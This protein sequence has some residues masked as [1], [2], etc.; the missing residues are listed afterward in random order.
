VSLTLVAFL[1]LYC[2]LGVACLMRHPI[3][4]VIG[5]YVTYVVSPATRWWGEPAANLGFRFNYIIAAVALLG[6]LLHYRES[7]TN[8][9]ISGQECLLW[10]YVGI[11]WFAGWMHPRIAG[12][13]DQALKLA[14]AVLMLSVLR[15][16][17]D[18]VGNFRW[19]IWALLLASSYGA[20][21]TRL[22]ADRIGN[23]VQSGAGGSDFLE[24]NFLAAHLTM[25]LP[26]LGVL[27]IQG[28]W[29]SKLF[30]AAAAA[31][32][33]D[34]IIQCRSRGAFLALL[35]GGAIALASAPRTYRKKI[36][37]LA[38]AGICGALVLVDTGFWD[39]IGQITTHIDVEEQDAS[40]AGRLLAWRAAIGMSADSPLGV[41]YNNF[42]VHVGRYSP[43]IPGKDT[44]ST[45]LRALAEL[46]FQ[47]LALLVLLIGNALYQTYRLHRWM[48]RE[49]PSSEYQLYVYATGASLVTY[50]IACTFISS[51]YVEEFYLILLFPDLLSGVRETAR[52]ENSEVQPELTRDIACA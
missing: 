30:L 48:R 5:Y 45:Y 13:E 42:K 26:F 17:I 12:G 50:L 51:T 25:I 37:V 21:D 34:V 15:R 8:R 43:T 35:G 39:R 3:Y 40:S 36:Y 11:V 1:A 28:R 47:G 27:F 23:R 7:K 14:K 33:V 52:C 24:G 41:G 49:T 2:A 20:L 6:V 9:S 10:A 44:H 29:K 38:L 18:D 4:G 22:M 16:S 31:V 32:I 19:F 46:G